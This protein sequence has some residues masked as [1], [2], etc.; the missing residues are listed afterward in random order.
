ME[1]VLNILKETIYLLVESSIYIIF[2]LIISGL[3]RIFLSPRLR[4]ESD[5]HSLRLQILFVKKSPCPLCF[6]I[7]HADLGLSSKF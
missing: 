1:I 4:F 6:Q 7:T 3:V 5:E 2:G